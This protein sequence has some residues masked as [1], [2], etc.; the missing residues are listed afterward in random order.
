MADAASC[1][2]RGLTAYGLDELH[3]TS[4]TAP[5]R[6]WR[7][8]RLQPPPSRTDRAASSDCRAVHAG[9][10]DSSSSGRRSGDGFTAEYKLQILQEACRPH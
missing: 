4:A 7:R 2:L 6:I 1:A 9:V 5:I 8:G 10:D 3:S